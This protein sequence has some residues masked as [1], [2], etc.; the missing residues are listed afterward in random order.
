M[1]LPIAARNNAILAVTPTAVRDTR[2][3]QAAS[4][5]A[6]PTPQKPPTNPKALDP[7]VSGQARGK[8]KSPAPGK[9]AMQSS[10]QPT[11]AQAEQRVMVY[12]R[13]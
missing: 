1:K 5:P 3:A 13:Q 12:A 6:N 7:T 8:G 2:L 4:G 9:A 11:L 10:A